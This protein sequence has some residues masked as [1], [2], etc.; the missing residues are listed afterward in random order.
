MI[1]IYIHT[2]IYIY[3]YIGVC[4]CFRFFGQL[5][6]GYSLG[7]LQGQGLEAWMIQDS[8]GWISIVEQ[9]RGRLATLW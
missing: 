7:Y 8:Q 1:Y 5:R 4:V 2:Y 6:Y 3:I 9:R